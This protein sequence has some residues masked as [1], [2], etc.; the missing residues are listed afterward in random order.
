M[1]SGDKTAT[2][3][4]SFTSKPTSLLASNKEFFF[5]VSM[6]SVGSHQHKPEAD[7]SHSI[8]VPFDFLDLP[9]NIF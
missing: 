3:T 6:L 2:Y 1:H 4:Q 8:S 7:V 5:I 9:N